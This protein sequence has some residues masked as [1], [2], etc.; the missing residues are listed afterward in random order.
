MYSHLIYSEKIQK[1]VSQGDKNGA[2][3]SFRFPSISK[4]SYFQGFVNSIIKKGSATMVI[5][6]TFIVIALTFIVIALTLI[7]N[8]LARIVNVLTRIINVL[9]TIVNVFATFVN[10]FTIRADV[11]ARTANVFAIPL[12]EF[13]KNIHLRPK[14]CRARDKIAPALA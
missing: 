2:L 6:L 10:V 9:A 11:F 13:T 4:Y 1:N 14:I 8:A 7:V 5:A 3:K 12:I